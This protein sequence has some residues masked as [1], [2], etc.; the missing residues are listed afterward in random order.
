MGYIFRVDKEDQVSP[1]SVLGAAGLI[2]DNGS[3]AFALAGQLYLKRDTYRVTSAFLQG[4]LNYNLYGIGVG[5]GNA[6]VKLPLTQEGSV[7]LGEILRRIKWQF[8]V[9]PRIIAGHSSV[10]TRSNGDL[11]ASVPP[12]IGLD[13]KLT[14][15]GFVIN[16]D[17]RDN[18]FFPR[19]GT[20]F[21]FTSDFFDT[22]LGSKYSFQSFRTTFNKYW[23]LTNKQVLAYNAHFC[24]TGGDPPFYGNCI[25][26]TH[27]ELRGYEA[28]RYIDR[29]M[30]ATQ[31]EYRVSLPKRFGVVGFGGIGGVA[32][33]A[34]KFFYSSSFL[35]AGGGGIRFLLSKS[36]HVNLRADIAAGK[37]EHTVSMGIS[38]AF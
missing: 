33:G 9:G 21:E 4:N 28:G 17:T 16:R 19:A 32:P 22:A 13:T 27:N 6:G 5:A 24:A 15:L 20:M 2:T 26:G 14:S 23:G 10:V 12:D 38:E 30:V 7:F 25:Y 29:F 11:G 8:F 34:R 3:R 1:P 37:N 18:R 35:P 36:Y 31:L